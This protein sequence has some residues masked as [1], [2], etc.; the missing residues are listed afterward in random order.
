MEL[1]R[2]VR[3]DG[4]GKEIMFHKV[5]QKGKTSDKNAIVFHGVYDLKFYL[6]RQDLKDT[7]KAGLS[8][9]NNMSKALCLAIKRNKSD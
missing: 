9:P 5:F 1:V 4:V 3:H 7:P 8:A 6:D 2:V